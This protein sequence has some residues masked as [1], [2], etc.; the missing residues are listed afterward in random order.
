M[1]GQFA[2]ATLEVRLKAVRDNYRFFRT[3]AKG[4][5][6]AAVVKANCYGLGMKQIA[7]M[8]EKLGCKTFFVAN[9][10]EAIELRKYISLSSRVFVFHGV[11]ENELEE[12]D[13]HYINPVLNDISQVQIFTNFAKQLGKK[14]NCSIHFDT[15]MNRL[16]IDWQ[17]AE[18]ISEMS[19]LE[20]LNINFLMS[21]LSC[22]TNLEHPLN[23]QQLDRSLHIKKYFPDHKY[24]LANSRGTIC[25]DDYL[26]D[27]V[28]PGSGLYGICG[29]L[30]KK[31]KIQNTVSL[32]AK[33]IQIRTLKEKGGVSY[34]ATVTAAK[35]ARLAVCPIGYADGFLRS[36]SNNAYGCLHG[37]KVPLLGIVSMDL[38]I[39]DISKVPENLVNLHDEIEF[40]GK[41]ISIDD[42]AKAANTIGYEILTCLGNRYKKKYID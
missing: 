38:T 13:K 21:H 4:A 29:D 37:Y 36:L 18:K 11:K 35:G 9:L 42:V 34:G 7:P 28:R 33:I 12:F 3:Q 2:D 15:G 25:G 30:H 19:D 16:G 1:N 8:F 20:S 5:E 10:D 31:N 40:I 32:K 23:Q 14:L 22:I 27:I 6:T 17:D 41:H 24:S 26:H 39:F